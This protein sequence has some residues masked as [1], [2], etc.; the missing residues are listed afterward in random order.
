[1]SET[2]VG[3]GSAPATER[4]SRR[5]AGPIRFDEWP[6]NLVHGVRTGGPAPGMARREPGLEDDGI[7]ISVLVVWQSMHRTIP[8]CGW[9]RGL[10]WSW[11]TGVQFVV[12]WWHAS[13]ERA[14]TKCPA[15]LGVAQF[16][17]WQLAQRPGPTPAWAYVT[18]FQAVVRWQAS[19]DS[20]VRRCPPGVALALPPGRW[21]LAQLP[22]MGPICA[23]D[24]H[25]QHRSPGR[26]R[27][28]RR[29]TALRVVAVDA[30]RGGGAAFVV[31]FRLGTEAD[32]EP[33]RSARCMASVA[34]KR[35]RRPG[36][37]SPVSSRVG[38]ERAVRVR[39]D[40]ALEA[41]R[42]L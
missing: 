41:A 16:P 31:A 35:R 23:R 22:G 21:Q 26:R 34:L 27:C 5:C 37:R 9:Y 4:R 15:G 10:K 11:K 33:L 6:L 18:G 2:G 8:A 36:T 17:V 14:V 19:Q 12:L 1:M 24:L 32:P 38:H 30:V 42:D 39:N 3:V 29:E 20:V 40:G 28:R 13:Q 25:R 7:T